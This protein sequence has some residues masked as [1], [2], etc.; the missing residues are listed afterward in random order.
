MTDTRSF[1]EIMLAH[2]VPWVCRVVPGIQHEMARLI[3]VDAAGQEV[4]LFTMLRVIEIITNM[5]AA[6]QAA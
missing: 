1:P 5:Q 4:P 6:R 3:L 2:P